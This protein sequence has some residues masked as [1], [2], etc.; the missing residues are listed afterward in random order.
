MFD[1]V[2]TTN[3]LFLV[4]WLS[5][6]KQMYAWL[7]HPTTI[8]GE[9]HLGPGPPDVDWVVNHHAPDYYF[10]LGTQPRECGV[11]DSPRW[12]AILE[13]IW[14]LSPKIFVA[15]ASASSLTRSFESGRLASRFLSHR[16]VNQLPPSKAI[17]FGHSP[18]TQAVE[19]GHSPPRFGTTLGGG[20]TSPTCYFGSG[21]FVSR[22]GAGGALDTC[23][24]VWMEDSRKS[25]R[26]M[27]SWKRAPSRWVWAPARN[28]IIEN[29]IK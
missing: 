3:D 9:W 20:S 28:R 12:I 10:T 16:E 14:A 27:V 19:S 21:R 23:Q 2:K 11:V 7:D 4:V 6:N 13:K 29:K 24:E 1:F 22:S 5:H 8:E 15:W 17:E 25:E 18:P 26:G